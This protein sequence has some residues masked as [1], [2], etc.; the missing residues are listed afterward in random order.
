MDNMTVKYLTWITKAQVNSPI[1]TS[2]ISILHCR[3]K[4]QEFTSNIHTTTTKHPKVAIL[5]FKI[6]N[7][8][9]ISSMTKQ[10]LN[11]STTSITKVQMQ[12][13]TFNTSFKV[14]S[15]NKCL[16]HR[17]VNTRTNYNSNLSL[18]N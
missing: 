8:I 6:S 17:T 11:G 18:I 10:V 3:S 1:Q 13:T 14:N 12:E 15:N 16:T 7:L 2:K 9:R 5:N 4:I